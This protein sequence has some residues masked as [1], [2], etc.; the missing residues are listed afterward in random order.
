MIEQFF[1]I[2]LGIQLIHSI[3]ELTNDFHGKFPLVKM[4]FK[5]FLFFE[6]LFFGFWTLVGVMQ[7]F[8]YEMNLWPSL[9]F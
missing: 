1:F 2:M 3:E 8:Q 4:K 5:T 7:F 9:L 6:I